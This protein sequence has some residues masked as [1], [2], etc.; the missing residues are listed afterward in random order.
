MAST[1]ALRVIVQGFRA[2]LHSLPLSWRKWLRSQHGLLRLYKATLHKSQLFYGELAPKKNLARYAKVLRE[3]QRVMKQW[4]ADHIDESVNVVVLCVGKI[5]LD[6]SL[7]ELQS[8]PQVNCVYVIHDSRDLDAID[9]I[10][11]VDS[12]QAVAVDK[13]VLVLRS[14]EA[15]VPEAISTFLQH[16]QADIDLISCDTDVCD[17]EGKSLQPQCFPQWDPDLQLATGYLQTGVLINNATLLP[18]ML[19]HVLLYQHAL[20]LASWL[21]SYAFSK[22][23]TIKHLPF[24]LLHMPDERQEPWGDYLS[25]SIDR[26]QWPIVIE[27]STNTSVVSIQWPKNDEPLVSIIIPTRNGKELVDVCISSILSKTDYSNFEILL[28]DN[29]S[30]EQ[31]SLEYFAALEANEPRVRVLQYDLPFNYSAINNFAVEHAKGSVLAFVNNDI[32]VISE[33]WL[34]SMVRHAQRSEI[35]CVGAKLFYP[36]KRIQHAGVVLGYGG[37]AG[38]AHKHYPDYHPGYLN[39]LIATHRY[40]AVTAACL[41]MRKALFDTVSGF[42]ETSLAV[43]FNDVDLCLKVDALGYRNLYCAEAMLFHHESISRGDENTPEKRKRFEK[44][45][46]YLQSQWAHVIANDPAYNPNLTLRQENFAIRE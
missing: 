38:H 42:N 19:E 40:S 14:G 18:S 5:P 37:G 3:Q 30:D 41:V 28:I 46:S 22:T 45:L 9:N 13:P 16:I 23:T 20:G 43:A 35:G 29:Q 26:L 2:V 33:N 36:N 21:A 7:K 25:S 32:E 24:T 4:H 34:S 6:A 39:R 17:S 27:K 1:R 31:E 8:N 11:F 10:V 44:E 15:L 12:P